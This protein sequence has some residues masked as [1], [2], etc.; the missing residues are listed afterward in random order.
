MT[1]KTPKTVCYTCITS[2]YDSIEALDF[3]LVCPGVDF[4]CFTDYPM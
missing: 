4:I 2:L 3:S 1:D